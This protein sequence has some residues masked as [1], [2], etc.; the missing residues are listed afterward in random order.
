LGT[1]LAHR[2]P[3]FFRAYV[4]VGQVTD[5]ESEAELADRFI[6]TA[7]RERDRPE[8]AVEL[9]A[10]GAA[11]REKW[12]FEFGGELHGETSFLPLILTGLRAS[13]YS[14]RDAMNVARGSSWSSAHMQWNAL[15]G[16]LS[17][18][19]LQVEIPVFFF[20][21]R[22]DWVTPS[23]L[24]IE[25][26]DRL[27][28]PRKERVWFERSAHFPFFEQPEKFARQMRWVLRETAD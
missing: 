17:E 24:A 14:W 11:V 7:A 8:A 23:S 26:L 5:P 2:H 15:D 9:D 16:P 6:R 13:E 21:G 12:L 19:I 28:A 22:H 1:L 3:E 27:E 4:G 20:L 10:H 25:Y 18:K